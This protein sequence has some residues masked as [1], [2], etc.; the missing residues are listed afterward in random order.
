MKEWKIK[1]HKQIQCTAIKTK[2]IPR[3]R[4]KVQWFE[5]GFTSLATLAVDGHQWLMVLT[6]AKVGGGVGGGVLC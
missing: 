3:T 4:R 2:R 5:I 6:L 1:Q